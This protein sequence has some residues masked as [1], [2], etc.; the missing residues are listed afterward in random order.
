LKQTNSS[1]KVEMA[2]SLPASKIKKKAMG[3]NGL[4]KLRGRFQRVIL[5]IRQISK[6]IKFIILSKPI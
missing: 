5:S 2:A 4:A 6:P 1:N 3:C